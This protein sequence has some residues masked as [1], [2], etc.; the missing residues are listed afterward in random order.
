MSFLSIDTRQAAILADRY[1]DTLLGEPGSLLL[2]LIQAPLLGAAIAGVFANLARDSLMLYFVM[3]LAAFFLGAVNSAREIVKER[4]LF[5]REK[6]FN[7]NSGAYF[8]SKLR[9]QSI[10][11]IVQ[12]A[13]LTAV[14]RGFVPLEVNLAVVMV[15]VIATAIVGAAI[16]LLISASVASTDRAVALVPLVVIPQILF[17]DFAI[18]RNKLANWTGVAEELMPVRWGYEILREMT[19]A[20]PSYG[21]ILLAGLVLVAIALVSSMLAMLGLSAARYE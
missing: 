8:L 17:S 9:I 6:M 7:L 3:C 10:V 21:R 1:L 2:M 15:T 18:G 5:L 13:S 4:A 16:G 12:G 14:V 20:S 19:L 11:G